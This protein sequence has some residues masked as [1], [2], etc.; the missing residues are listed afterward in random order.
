M[1]RLAHPLP[2]GLVAPPPLPA[3][4]TAAVS[5]YHA[6]HT[7]PPAPRGA[8]ASWTKGDLL[9]A[10]AFGRVYLALDDA[11]GEL[12]AVKQVPLLAPPGGGG[13]GGLN[14]IPSVAG[15]SAGGPAGGAAL[16][17]RQCLRLDGG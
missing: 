4:P 6:P 15:R 9:G 11:S 3:P 8:P 16:P 12:M 2:P 17:G 5:P 13:A 1:R 10:G 14:H 7:P